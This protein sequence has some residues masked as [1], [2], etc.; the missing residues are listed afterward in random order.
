MYVGRRVSEK[1]GATIWR[2]YCRVKAAEARARYP[3][4]KLAAARARYPRDK[5]RAAQAR[6][7]ASS[8]RVRIAGVETTYRVSPDR[9]AEAKERLAAFRE[10]QR[11]RGKMFTASLKEER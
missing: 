2:R 4:E 7:R 1:T 8:L 11:A 5:Q 9:L 3:R 10:E 6:Y